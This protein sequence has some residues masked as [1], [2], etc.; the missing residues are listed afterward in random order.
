MKAVVTDSSALVA[1]AYPN[2]ADHQKALALSDHLKRSGA[3]ILI[4]VEVIAET[5]NILGKKQGRSF[6]VAFGEQILNDPDIHPMTTSNDRMRDAVARWQDQAGGVSY[7]DCLVMA[8]ADETETNAGE[9]PAIF[10]FDEV[11]SK[12]GYHLPDAA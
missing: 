7:T 2:D 11:F 12:N 4:P 8:A 1:L 10:G 3:L 6:A 5:L 9:K